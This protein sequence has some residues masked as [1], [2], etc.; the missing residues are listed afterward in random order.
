MPL[1]RFYLNCDY[2]PESAVH[3]SDA[4]HHHLARVVKCSVGE[5]VQLVNGRGSIA[6]AKIEK[7]EKRATTL[8]IFSVKTAQVEQSP[9]RMVVPFMRPSKMEWV[10]EKGTELG[11][12]SFILYRAAHSEK[13]EISEHQR[14]RFYLLM[15]SALKQSGRLFLPHLEILPHLKSA[16]ECEDRIFFGDPVAP[17]APL[18][19]I[20]QQKNQPTL[21]VTGPERGF[22]SDELSLLRQRGSAV[23]INPH[24]LRA[25]TA[26]LAALAILVGINISNTSR[27]SHNT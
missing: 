16:L 23:R 19:S 25:E 1:D 17:I 11:A 26:P 14:E 9:I 8:R 4:E 27:E 13:G 22:S 2:L 10:I 21:F 6:E 12:D 15:I 3:L 24:I 20:F 5:T 7:V 18:T